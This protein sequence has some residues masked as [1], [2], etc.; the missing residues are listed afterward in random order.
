MLLR[1]VGSAEETEELEAGYVSIMTR[2][3]LVR[4]GA[5]GPESV[6]PALHKGWAMATETVYP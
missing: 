2:R 4:C 1:F 5:S 3:V 6:N